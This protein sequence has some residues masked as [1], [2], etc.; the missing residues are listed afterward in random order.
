MQSDAKLLADKRFTPE[1]E[2]PAW[3][4]AMGE[5]DKMIERH[6]EYR[7]F[8][9]SKIIRAL[10][11]GFEPGPLNPMLFPFQADIVRWGVRKGRCSFW[12]DCGLGKTIQQIEWARLVN[13]HTG[14]PVLIF[15]PLAV[16]R[17]TLA[18]S[19]KFNGPEITLCAR[20]SDVQPGINITNYEK[21]EHFRPEV[22]GGIVLDES[23]IL[24]GYD[25]ATRKA[26]TEFAS[27]IAYRLCCTATP[28]PNDYMEL[29]NHAEFLG[30]MKLSEM[31][32][33][34]FVHDGGD[35]SK[36][37]LKRHA[38]EEFWKWICS[39]AVA[40]RKPSDLGYED[41]N[42]I[43]P[44][45][46][47]HQVTVEA[48]PQENYLFPVEAAT[49][50][51]RRTARRESIGDRIKAC[52]DIV[53]HEA[54][55]FIVWCNL[56]AES[57][58]LT[59]ALNKAV[60]VTGSDSDRHKEESAIGFAHGD[61]QVMVS[62]PLIF[63]YGMNFQSCHKVAFVGLS[64]SY[65]QFYQA[66]RRCWRFGQTSPVDCYVITSEA[67]GAVVRNIE[68]KEAEARTM[69][70]GMVEQMKTEM[71]RQVREIE[72]AERHLVKQESGENWRVIN[73]DCVEEVAMLQCNSIDY[74][75]F[76]PPFA[77][78]YTYSQS[79][80]DMG[81]CRSDSDFY[82]HF[83][84]LIS[85][86]M[87]V[88]KPGRLLS[89]HCMN[90]PMTKER[91]GVIGIRDFRGELI[92]MFVEA[93]FI[94]HSE[95]V[96]WKDP[97][98]AMQR[99]KAIG[100]LYKQLRKDS[101]ISRQGIPDYLVT[102]RKP[103]ENP[104][105]VTKLHQEFPVS[106]WQRYA[107]PVWMDINPS[108]TLQ[109]ES[110]R[111]QE[112]ERHICPLQLEVIERAV[113]LWTNPG[114]LVLSPFAGIGSEGFVALQQGRRFVGVELKESYWKQA[115]ANLHAAKQTQTKLFDPSK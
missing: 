22:F 47:M 33:V 64:D 75:I 112:D 83:R 79:E 114:D 5:A 93:G 35:T 4:A 48:T 29:G 66:I 19:R 101:C 13:E 61:L 9:E 44:Q 69:M 41:G 62:K 70:N 74:S 91:D 96:I 107:S 23:S 8:L 87:R 6:L 90:L 11:C 65:E 45:L 85:D 106:L 25:G 110:A 49:L 40:I 57:E 68:R 73:G 82:D 105:P 71:Q 92:R 54:D 95:V 39:W 53:N 51:E 30:V 42:F 24:K 113:Q 99:T 56:N 10:P 59:A 109:R 34:F 27:G 17:Q 14:K 55:Q 46:R 97:V 28:A 38:K 50:E 111:E 12:E 58:A 80:R 104:E 15:A 89:F 21:L 37:R 81:N 52:A 7:K 108:D 84:F 78:L 88:L 3:L 26:L 67:E 18:E 31:L 2:S 86:L 94:Y 32:A 100:L 43:L 63:G 77:S 1:P 16:S 102:M 72:V 36:W 20:M 103:G 60:E 76:S 98:T 115:V